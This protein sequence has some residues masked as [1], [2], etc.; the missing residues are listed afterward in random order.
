MDQHSGRKGSTTDTE[1]GKNEA[2]NDEK[3]RSKPT[4]SLGRGEECKLQP[5]R[6]TYLVL[7]HQNNFLS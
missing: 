7:L 5:S 6:T 2:K 1:K 3:E 4:Q